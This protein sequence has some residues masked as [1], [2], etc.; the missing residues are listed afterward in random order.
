MELATRM[1]VLAFTY[2]LFGTDAIKL[3][4]CWPFFPWHTGIFRE[5][6]LQEP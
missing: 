1:T 4:R 6:K 5:I 2:S 3:R